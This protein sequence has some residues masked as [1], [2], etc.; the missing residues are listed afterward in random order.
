MPQPSWFTWPEFVRNITFSLFCAL[1]KMS[2]V[3]FAFSHV[4]WIFLHVFGFF[5]PHMSENL[6]IFTFSHANYIHLY[7]YIIYFSTYKSKSGLMTLHANHFSNCEFHIFTIFIFYMQLS[8]CL[9]SENKV[10]S[11]R[12]LQLGLDLKRLETQFRLEIWDNLYFNII[13]LYSF[14]FFFLVND[15]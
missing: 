4:N 8:N 14:F 7:A 6:H 1:T 11:Q 3:R 9:T 12:C 10:L 13:L 15:H 2:H 5:F